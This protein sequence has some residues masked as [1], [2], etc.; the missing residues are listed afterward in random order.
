MHSETV[1]F[2]AYGLYTFHRNKS[3]SSY[4]VSLPVGAVVLLTKVG[5]CTSGVVSDSIIFHCVLKINVYEKAKR[6][7]CIKYIMKLSI[8]CGK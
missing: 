5:Q 1:D 3:A 4:I 2:Y 6:I 7:I 8:Q